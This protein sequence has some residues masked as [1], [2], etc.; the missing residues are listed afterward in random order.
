M[1]KHR[2]YFLEQILKQTII[3]RCNQ[4][5][6]RQFVW[7]NQI[8]TNHTCADYTI[9][10]QK[11]VFRQIIPSKI[12][13]ICLSK[14][15]DY[16]LP[17]Q[18]NKEPNQPKAEKTQIKYPKTWV[19]GKMQE[20]KDVRTSKFRFLKFF[21]MAVPPPNISVRNYFSTSSKVNQFP[22]TWKLNI[23]FKISFIFF[24]SVFS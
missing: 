16:H 9:N 10:S 23:I 20:R 6:I 19:Y 14:I 1:S 18:A 7:T 3:L 5:L 13:G 4:Y 11:I 24:S 12:F 17:N 15:N 8:Q 2:S 22:Q 21:I